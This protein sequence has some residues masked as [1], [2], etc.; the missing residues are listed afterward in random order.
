MVN[1]NEKYN[2]NEKYYIDRFNYSI[3]VEC[4]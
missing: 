4:L 1:N 3:I 2:Y